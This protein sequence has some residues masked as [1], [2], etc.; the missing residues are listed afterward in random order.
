MQQYVIADIVHLT[1]IFGCYSPHDLQI[2]IFIPLFQF[3]ESVGPPEAQV[4]HTSIQ[5]PSSA[6]ASVAQP[7]SLPPDLADIIF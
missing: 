7:E 2:N 1:Q 5:P 4:L 6:V 3:P